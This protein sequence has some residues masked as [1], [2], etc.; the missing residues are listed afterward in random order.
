MNILETININTIKNR[1]KISRRDLTPS[2]SK[3]GE[4]IIHPIVFDISK[5]LTSH[6]DRIP[7]TH[8][9]VASVQ[10]GTLVVF[11]K[12]LAK[13]VA[14]IPHIKM[15]DKKVDYPLEN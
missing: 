1:R 10:D 7:P 6:L 4:A 2:L 3:N 12:T 9:G 5:V 11:N 13:M 14:R 15:I 8:D